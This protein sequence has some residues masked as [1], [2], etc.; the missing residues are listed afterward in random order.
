MLTRNKNSE[1]KQTHN[2]IQKR[3]ISDKT[4][5]NKK[6]MKKGYMHHHVFKH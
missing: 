1:T 3:Q 4:E 6:S 5:Q 2:N